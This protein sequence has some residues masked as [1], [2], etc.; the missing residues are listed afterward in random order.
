MKEL[1][2]SC[3]GGTFSA[4]NTATFIAF[5]GVCGRK[6][7]RPYKWILSFHVFSAEELKRNLF[8]MVVVTPVRGG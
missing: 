2:L 1:A 4:L 6:I 5:V 3:R 8:F 7:L